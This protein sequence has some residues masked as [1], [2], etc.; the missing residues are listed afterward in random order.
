MSSHLPTPP[1]GPKLSQDGKR[2]PFR[3]VS[4]E[5]LLS[6]RSVKSDT[7]VQTQDK[8]KILICS[9]ADGTLVCKLVPIIL[10]LLPFS[11]AG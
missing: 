10:L 6:H 1:C 2:K 5:K 8:K 11:P 9:Y 7:E 4:S 3:R